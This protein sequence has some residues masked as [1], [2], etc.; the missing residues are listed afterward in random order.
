MADTLF[1]KL[2]KHEILQ[3]GWHLARL[4]VK[5]DFAED[6]YSTD[7]F[8][9]ELPD[10]IRELSN[11]IKTDT[12]VPRPLL[13]MEVPKG[14]MGFRPGSVVPIQD[15]VVVS[16]IVRLLAPTIDKKLSD[17]IYSWRLKKPLSNSGPIFQ[18]NHAADLP[19]LKKKTIRETIDPFT[20][21]Y[22]VWPEFD[23]DSR[24]T[25][26]KYNYRYLATS[27]IAAYFENIQLPILREGLIN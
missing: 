27:D 1:N 5:Q 19:F 13:R 12:Y 21:W 6:L 26:G 3:K 17:G 23:S 9:H 10:Q 22:S 7:V 14:R 4:D 20:P 18:E 15:R 16:S 11:R 25:F 2:S 24:T 8:G